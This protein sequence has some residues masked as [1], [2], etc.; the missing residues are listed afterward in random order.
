[1][2]QGVILLCRRPLSL[3]SAWFQSKDLV[4]RHFS[5]KE[6]EQLIRRFSTNEQEQPITWLYKRTPDQMFKPRIVLGLS[7][8]HTLYWLW[9]V[10]DFIPTVNA[11]PQ[12]Y[13]HID[14]VVG[15]VGIILA[16]FCNLGSLL[17][18][19]SLIS[20][21]GVQGNRI[22]VFGHS[23]PTTAPAEKG[24]AYEYGEVF[25]DP[26]SHETKRILDKG[27]FVKGFIALKAA[28]RRLPYLLQ[29]QDTAEVLDSLTLLDMLT[30]PNNKPRLKK[31]QLPRP[32]EVKR[33]RKR[34]QVSFNRK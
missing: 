24:V 10:I 30:N 29:I 27:E 32:K 31:I 5:T 7:S 20:R 28:D 11:S 3:S 2:R 17:Y 34:G 4:S 16:L 14:P 15:A 12:E 6:E 23:L 21:I 26:S 22:C 1:M 25:M 33:A 13:L 18:P 19:W 8:F 9:Y